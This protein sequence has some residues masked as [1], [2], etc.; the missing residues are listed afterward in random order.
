M[1]IVNMK[2]FLR[3]ISILF[4]LLLGIALFTSKTYSNAKISYKEEIICSG[5]NLWAISK[6]EQK[7]NKYFQNKDIRD[8]IEEI[9]QIN[10][11]ENS[12]LAIGQKIIIP[13][14]I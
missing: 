9:K 6:N 8:I 1:R 4:L 3:T 7:N 11:L 14:Y 5:D 13:I 10:D 12:N 2:K